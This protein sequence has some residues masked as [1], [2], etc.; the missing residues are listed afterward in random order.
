MIVFTA[1]AGAGFSTWLALQQI[2]YQA[3]PLSFFQ[4]I[5]LIVMALFFASIGV[6][7]A[8][9]A[10][11]IFHRKVDH[12]AD[13]KGLVV[14][15]LYWLNGETWARY[16]GQNENTGKYGFSIFGINNP[17]IPGDVKFLIPGIVRT[18]I[19]TQE[20]VFPQ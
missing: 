18:Y 16:I 10:D 3:E 20:E 1:L 13:P 14:G 12:P 2:S 15:R 9:T 6:Y 19:S 11:D 4:I 7:G 5:C 8:I 17:D